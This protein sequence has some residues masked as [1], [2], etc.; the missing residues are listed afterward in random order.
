MDLVN[1]LMNRSQRKL[2][3]M[4]GVYSKAV[5]LILLALGLAVFG[6]VRL[7]RTLEPGQRPVLY[8]V[9]V[10]ALVWLAFKLVNSGI[11]GRATDGG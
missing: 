8:L 10:L 11:I 4:P 5:L 9:F 6:V 3:R 7:G 2:P 1:L